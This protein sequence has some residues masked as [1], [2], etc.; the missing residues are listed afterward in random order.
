LANSGQTVDATAV[1]TAQQR[2]GL[3]AGSWANIAK[4][5]YST[6]PF[7][8]SAAAQHTE[9]PSPEAAADQAT[10]MAASSEPVDKAVAPA[11]P[12]EDDKL[13]SPEA[14]ADQTASVAASWEPVDKAVAPA[15]PEEDDK[16][17]AMPQQDVDT[18]EVRMESI[19]HPS[20]QPV[21][22]EDQ[23]AMASSPEV[24]AQAVQAQVLASDTVQG[25]ESEADAAIDRYAKLQS[26]AESRENQDNQQSAENAER[27]DTVDEQVDEE[28]SLLQHSRK[29]LVSVRL[30]R[31]FD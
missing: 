7:A 11:I 9:P 15:I 4:Q 3:G 30:R 6:N 24:D 27:D 22:T 29:R 19:I 10:S 31:G 1:G 2:G 8:A 5:L 28:S 12:A 13:P 16:L 14:A 25:Q 26:Q 17:A 23:L 18:Q 20:P 21:A